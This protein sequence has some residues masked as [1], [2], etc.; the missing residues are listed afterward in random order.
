V[1][2]HALCKGARTTGSPY[3]EYR[4]GMSWLSYFLK[5]LFSIFLD[6]IHFHLV[7]TSAMSAMLALTMSALA[8][9]LH[10]TSLH[11]TSLHGTSLH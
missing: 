7:T 1:D 11:G 2:R 10:G 6:E 5:E 4:Y 3:S 8:A 9:F